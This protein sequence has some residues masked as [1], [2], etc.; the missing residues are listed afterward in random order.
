[1]ASYD[2]GKFEIVNWVKRNFPEG[3][4]CL[5]VGACDGKWYNLLGDYLKMDACEVFLP[6]IWEHQLDLKYHKVFD[7][8]IVD[9][10]Y[11]RYDLIIFGDVIEHMT[12]ANAQKALAYAWPRCKNLIVGVPWLYAQGALYGNTYEVHIQDDLTPELFAERYPDLKLLYNTGHK[13]AY[14]YKGPNAELG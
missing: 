4:T 8:D 9:L 1:M 2:Y 6:N 12:V 10:K 14:Y 13:Y 5:D 7:C 3:S 11:V